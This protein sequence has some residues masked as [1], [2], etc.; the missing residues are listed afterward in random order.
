VKK[1]Q[2]KNFTPNLC[3]KI[4]IEKFHTDFVG[5]KSNLKF[6]HSIYF[7]KKKYKN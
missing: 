2:P 1:I 4:L 5:K 7:F 6:S 3:E